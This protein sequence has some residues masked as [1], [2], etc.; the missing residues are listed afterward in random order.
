VPLNLSVTLAS[1]PGNSGIRG[2]FDAAVAR[3]VAGEL[4][5]LSIC[6]T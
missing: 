2:D 4:L 6:V 3:T 5:E 1:T